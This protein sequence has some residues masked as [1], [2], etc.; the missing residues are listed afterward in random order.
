[1]PPSVSSEHAFSSTGITI[2]KCCSCLKADIIMALQC[3]KCM[4]WHELIF[5]EP[6]PCSMLETGLDNEEEPQHA[7]G[8]DPAWDAIFLAD[9]ETDNIETEL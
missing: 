7:N 6:G 5:H 3:L 9:D 8:V 2:S 4:L 1:M